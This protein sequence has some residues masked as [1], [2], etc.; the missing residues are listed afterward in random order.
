ML[1]TGR[2]IGPRRGVTWLYRCGH[3]MVQEQIMS[4]KKKRTIGPCRGVTWLHRCRHGIS[5]LPFISILAFVPSF[6]SSPIS[7]AFVAEFVSLIFSSFGSF[8]SDRRWFF[9]QQEHWGLAMYEQDWMCL[10]LSFASLL[11]KLAFLQNP[12]GI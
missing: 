8:N 7:Q 4:V 2:T 1:Q 5:S 10:A 6:S 12:L 11:A 9:T 3:G